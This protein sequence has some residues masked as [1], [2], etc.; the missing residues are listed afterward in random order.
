MSQSFTGTNC[1]YFIYVL[2]I[3]GRCFSRNSHVFMDQALQNR[4]RFLG[5]PPRNGRDDHVCPEGHHGPHNDEN[6]RYGVNLMNSYL[7]MDTDPKKR[8]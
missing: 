1:F 7:F 6:D 8:Q 3:M 2:Y 5:S 4:H